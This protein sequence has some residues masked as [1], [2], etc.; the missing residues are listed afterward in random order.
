MQAQDVTYG[1]SDRMPEEMSEK[2]SGRM[3]EHIIYLHQPKPK[4]TKG[5]SEYTRFPLETR[6]FAKCLPLHRCWEIDA[7]ILSQSSSSTMWIMRVLA[8]IWSHR[9]ASKSIESIMRFWIVID[10]M[11]LLGAW[12]FWATNVT[13]DAPSNPSAE[14]VHVHFA[15]NGLGSYAKQAVVQWH[16]AIAVMASQ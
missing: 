7:S 5:S 15:G 6:G 10:I 3:P 4:K 11:M 14:S 9:V 8:D 2:M 16:G 13:V 1:M 12:Y